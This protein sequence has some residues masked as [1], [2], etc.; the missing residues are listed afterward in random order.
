MMKPTPLLDQLKKARGLLHADATV[1]DHLAIYRLG[2]S[3]NKHQELMLTNPALMDE[4]LVFWREVSV[5][6]G[7]GC[8]IMAIHISRTLSYIARCG[9][10]EITNRLDA[11]EQT[12]DQALAAKDGPV[13]Q[14]RLDCLARLVKEATA[15]VQGP[16]SRSR[17]LSKLRAN[18]W[19]LLSAACHLVKDPA[20][21]ELTLKTVG[22][23]K[24]N[25]IERMAAIETLEA[26][27]GDGLEISQEAEDALNS[28][29]DHPKKAG[30][31]LLVT[32]LQTKIDFGIGCE[33]GALDAV[34]EWKDEHEPGRW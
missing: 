20:L 17:H 26:Y 29:C 15:F 3:L 21:L 9:S 7:K 6:R 33:L 25:D 32:A 8:Q 27:F 5:F 2:E 34:D 4:V 31:S 12:L 14:T 1:A 24:A 30:R 22:N 16:R 10:T 23:A 13:I 19:V 28:I 11:A 18:F